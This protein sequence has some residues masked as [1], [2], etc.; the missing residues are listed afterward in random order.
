MQPTVGGVAVGLRTASSD[1]ER[2]LRPAPRAPKLTPPIQGL[3][4]PQPHMSV[5]TAPG[6]AA[7]G[8]L[9]GLRTLPLLLSVSKHPLQQLYMSIQATK[10]LQ[11][12]GHA[13][14]DT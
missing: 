1:P 9:T 5:W 10:S 12:I 2:N 7:A 6:Q 4:L 3:N 8:G 11:S 13:V 14:N